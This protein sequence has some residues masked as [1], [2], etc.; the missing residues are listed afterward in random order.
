MAANM[1]PQ[2]PIVNAGLSYINGLQ[3]S[4]DAVAP[5]TIINI[6]VGQCR[7]STNT[8]DIF[9]NAVYNTTVVPPALISNYITAS[10]AFVGVGGLDAGAVAANTMYAVYVIGSSSNM[11]YSVNYAPIN[12]VP[13]IELPFSLF[14]ARALLSTNFTAP[15]LPAGYDMFRRVGTIVTTA[16]SAIKAFTQVA[17]GSVRRMWYATP[18]VTDVA[19]DASTAG[20]FAPVNLN[21]T[22]AVPVQATVVH[23]SASI[24]PTA[25]GG[26]VQFQPAIADGGVTTGVYAALS[27]DVAAVAHVAPVSVP[28]GIIV[29]VDPTLNTVGINYASAGVTTLNVTGFDDQL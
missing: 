1:I 25:A 29:N 28:T 16:G 15:A 3:L 2:D 6:A 27:G 13:P 18:I 24:T 12:Q 26:L 11:P 20:V 19:A 17:S 9:V 14:P 7:D 5:N 21:V 22:P 8:N 23:L 10:T 4:N